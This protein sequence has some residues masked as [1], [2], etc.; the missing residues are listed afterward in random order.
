MKEKQI[1]APQDPPHGGSWRQDP[2][3]G[4]LVREITNDEL[5]ITNELED[6]QAS[7]PAKESE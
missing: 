2:T 6:R 3:N 5:R 7:E 4:E 1:A